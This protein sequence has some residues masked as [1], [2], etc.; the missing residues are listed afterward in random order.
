MLPFKASS[1]KRFWIKKPNYFNEVSKNSSPY[2]ISEFYGLDHFE[3][4]L[5]QLRLTAYVACLETPAT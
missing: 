1:Q 5:R 3:F 2:I 4:Q